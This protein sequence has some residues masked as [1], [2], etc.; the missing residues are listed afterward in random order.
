[1]S[2]LLTSPFYMC[3]W[4]AIPWH[5]YNVHSH[6]EWSAI[7]RETTL[8]LFTKDHQKIVKLKDADYPSLSVHEQ[9]N[10][11]LLRLREWQKELRTLY[12][13]MGN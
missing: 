3:E 1:M 7:S 12:E 8:T 5:E 6:K 10:W 13:N 2:Q 4:E 11:A 9:N